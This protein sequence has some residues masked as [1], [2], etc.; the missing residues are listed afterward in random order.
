MTPVLKGWNFDFNEKIKMLYIK[1]KMLY[2]KIKMLYGKI[3]ML[4]LYLALLVERPCQPCGYRNPE[5]CRAM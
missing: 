4:F 3:K 2:T 1:I 5:T